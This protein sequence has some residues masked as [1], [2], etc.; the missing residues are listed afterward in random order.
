M[1]I[2]VFY[3]KFEVA[4]CTMCDGIDRDL[5]FWQF[6]LSSYREVGNTDTFS[7]EPIQYYYLNI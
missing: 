2:S 1:Q 4:R 7:V 6:N 3:E 5:H